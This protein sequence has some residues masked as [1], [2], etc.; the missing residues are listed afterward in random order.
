M[1]ELTVE[2]RRVLEHLK[3]AFELYSK[4]PVQHPMH[5]LEFTLAIHQAQRLVMSRPTAR[6]EGWIIEE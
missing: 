5:Q 6:V 4:L 1:T 3:Q 2:E